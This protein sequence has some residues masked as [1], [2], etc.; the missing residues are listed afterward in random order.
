MAK[1]AKRK[2]VR[3]PAVRKGW[4]VVWPNG[5]IDSTLFAFRISAIEQ[6]D[7][8]MQTREDRHKCRVVRAEIREVRR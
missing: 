5:N 2:P 4:A 8:S 3:K 1:K 6:A 7:R